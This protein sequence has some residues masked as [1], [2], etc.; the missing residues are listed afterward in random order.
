MNIRYVTNL[1]WQGN[2]DALRILGELY[3][4][5]EQVHGGSEYR[6]NVGQLFYSVISMNYYN[7]F[8]TLDDP[9]EEKKLLRKWYSF[10]HDVREDYSDFWID[11]IGKY[12]MEYDMP[13][14]CHLLA[15]KYVFDYFVNQEGRLWVKLRLGAAVERGHKEAESLYRQLER[16]DEALEFARMEREERRRRQLEE[17]EKRS[18]ALRKAQLQDQLDN[19][20]RMLDLLG[21]GMGLTNQEQLGSGRK[22]YP[23]YLRDRD[24][25]KA[26]EGILR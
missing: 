8:R 15:R 11:R 13:E 16:E 19:L 17:D 3:M 2:E 23:D 21:G 26:M 20:E 7:K 4:D 22:G 12:A 10:E 9:E 24:F 1:A 14:F 6:R 18:E 5:F 25:R